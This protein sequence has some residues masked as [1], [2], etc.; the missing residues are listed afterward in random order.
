[1]PAM[2]RIAIAAQH[3]FDDGRDQ[4]RR[5]SSIRLRFGCR[6]DGESAAVGDG[7]DAA[8]DGCALGARAPIIPAGI[9]ETSA[10]GIAKFGR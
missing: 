4:Q 5:R 9:C 6:R 10:L 2:S 3:A 1:M 7:A 8:R